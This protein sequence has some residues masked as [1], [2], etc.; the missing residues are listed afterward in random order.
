MLQGSEY[1][2]FCEYM[3]YFINITITLFC[4]YYE[5]LEVLVGDPSGRLDFVLC[6]LLGVGLFLFVFL[7]FCLFFVFLSWCIYAFSPFCQIVLLSTCP[8]V[9]LSFCPIVPLYPPNGR[10]LWLSFTKSSLR[11]YIYLQWNY[12]TSKFE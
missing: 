3:R 6:A 1:L 7:S 5:I 4:R 11:W 10:V 9:P 2:I 8:V 12:K